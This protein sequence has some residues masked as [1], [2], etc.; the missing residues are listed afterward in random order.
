MPVPGADCPVA[1]TSRAGMTGAA[2]RCGYRT[3]VE[4]RLGAGTAPR[5]GAAARPKRGFDARPDAQHAICRCSRRP[6]DRSSPSNVLESGECQFMLGSRS[7]C[8]FNEILTI[9]NKFH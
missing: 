4:V 1:G 6:K 7:F 5:F 2:V 3:M 8:R 9:C